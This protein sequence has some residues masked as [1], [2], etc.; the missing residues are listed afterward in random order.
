MSIISASTIFTIGDAAP[1]ASTE[2]DIEFAT[3]AGPR[4]L[5]G[6]PVTGTPGELR[7]LIYPGGA[8]PTLTYT[9]N[10]DV[11][12]NFHT[13]PLDKRPRAFVSTTLTDNMLIGWIG[14]SRDVSIEE[15]WIGSTT[16]SRMDLDFF[17]ALQD[18]YRNPPLDGQFIQWAPRDRTSA[19]YYVVIQELS[20]SLSGSA[21]Q[22][23][24]DFEFDYIVTRYGYLA[25]TVTLKFAIIGE[26]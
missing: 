8:F 24:G 21:G 13:T 1:V 19:T 12:T 18:Y 2:A 16:Q 6:D 23:A 3:P 25:G 20:L 7:Q 15:R 17:L 9:T 5:P 22:G 10:P 14:K 4:T 26:V 11:Y